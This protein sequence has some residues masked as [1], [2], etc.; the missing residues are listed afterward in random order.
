[1]TGFSRD[2]FYSFIPPHSHKNL[3]DIPIFKN[4][5]LCQEG[6]QW[7]AFLS[8]PVGN[9]QLSSKLLPTRVRLKCDMFPR[10]QDCVT[11]SPKELNLAKAAQKSMA[12]DKRVL[13][14]GE[15]SDVLFSFNAGLNL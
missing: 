9:A 8:L 15:I 10:Q 13:S 11:K 6:G 3:S 2:I 1:M 4:L 14:R 12:A 7:N 5:I